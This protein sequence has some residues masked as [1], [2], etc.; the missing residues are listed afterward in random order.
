[1]AN[2]STESWDNTSDIS[3]DLILEETEPLKLLRACLSLV[4][5]QS[6]RRNCQVTIG[7]TNQ[8]GGVKRPSDMPCLYDLTEQFDLEV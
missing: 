3:S 6:C 2:I 8:C 5:T 1:M 7:F 4:I